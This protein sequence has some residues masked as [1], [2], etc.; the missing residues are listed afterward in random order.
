MTDFEGH[1]C[2]RNYTKRVSLL[3]AFHLSGK[4]VLTFT[5][6]PIAFLQSRIFSKTVLLKSLVITL[7]S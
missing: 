4:M 1:I 5:E 6:P 7:K 2:F 3:Q